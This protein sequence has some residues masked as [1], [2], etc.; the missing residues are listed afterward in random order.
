MKVESIKRYLKPYKMKGRSSTISNAFACALAPYHKFEKIKVVAAMKVLGLDPDDLK[1]IYCGENAATW[2]H[3]ISIVK[4]SEFRGYGHQ[5]GNLVP[6][7]RLCNESKGSKNFEDFLTQ[8][9]GSGRKALVKKL[10]R[11]LKRFSNEIDIK[12]SKKKY[13]A[14]WT[15]YERLRQDVLF[16]MVEADKIAEKLRESL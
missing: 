14:L 15:R 12:K 4:N 7:C 10:S 8:R 2:D 13:V 9:P 1:C 6:S 3:L 16:K 11:Y 5:I